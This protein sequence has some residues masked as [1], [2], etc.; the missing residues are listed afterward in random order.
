MKV[1]LLLNTVMTCLAFCRLESY[2]DVSTD[3]G[4]FAWVDT[5]LQKFQA[6]T[7]TFMTSLPII[8]DASGAAISRRNSDQ[9]ETTR[10]SHLRHFIMEKAH[11]SKLAE[12][13]GEPTPIDHPRYLLSDNDRFLNQLKEID[14]QFLTKASLNQDMWSGDYWGIYRGGIAARYNDRNFPNSLAWA[15]NYDYINANPRD[16][17]LN[18][19]YPLAM[20]TLS[21]A[22]KFDF[23]IDAPT[24]QGLAQHAWMEGKIIHDRHERVEA[25][26]G[27]CH[28]WAAAAYSN[29]R[30]NRTLHLRN[31]RGYLIPFLPDD[32]KA[33]FSYWWA[34]DNYTVGFVGGRCNT[35]RPE[36]DPATGRIVD[37]K[38]YDNNPSTW[39]LAVINL[40]GVNRRPFIMDAMFDQQVWNQPIKAYSF[41]YFNPKSNRMTTNWMEARVP[42]E[43]FP[44]DRFKQYRSQK[45][46][47]LIGIA[48]EVTYLE[49]SLTEHSTDSPA[50]DVSRTVRYLYD[51]EL[52]ASGTI[53]GGEWY[54]NAHP[55]FL[56]LP[57]PNTQPRSDFD[58]LFTEGWNLAAP[59]PPSWASI[60]RQAARQGQ[61]PASLIL[62]LNHAFLQN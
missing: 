35:S 55:D 14:D 38:C 54:Q 17:L 26:Y 39:H 24:G 46:A 51:L 4:D 3:R 10:H 61:I 37:P 56:W 21:P 36:T 6:D 5:E 20:A 59:M 15:D 45:A 42:T 8:V 2:A 29:P 41:T 40:I 12:R 16:H 50:N 60:L 30:P 27:I 48:M 58:H 57:K 7:A 32:I 18:T 62:Q 43:E 33:L 34:K 1:T 9:Q 49:E 31:P 47:S 11:R 13:K 19:N 23:L 52:D 44:E 25:W 53:V 28:G 22:E